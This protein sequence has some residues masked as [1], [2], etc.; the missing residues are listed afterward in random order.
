MAT[1]PPPHPPNAVPTPARVQTMQALLQQWEAEICRYPYGSLE[2]HFSPEQVKAI[3]RVSAV[4]Q[5]P[6]RTDG[7]IA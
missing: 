7:P 6:L 4:I 5:V 2:L 1:V 3:L